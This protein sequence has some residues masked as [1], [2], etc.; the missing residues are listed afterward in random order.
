MTVASY[1]KPQWWEQ[2]IFACVSKSSNWYKHELALIVCAYTVLYSGTC[3]HARVSYCYGE[4]SLFLYCNGYCGR[5]EWLVCTPTCYGDRGF[6]L[7]HNELMTFS[8]FF[9]VQISSARWPR[10]VFL[11]MHRIFLISAHLARWA[12]RYVPSSNISFTKQ[13]LWFYFF[14]FIYNNLVIIKKQY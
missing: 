9:W 13:Q 7:H 8:V 2:F 3:V 1:I 12:S 10:D 14:K 11:T 4:Q 5:Q 6:V